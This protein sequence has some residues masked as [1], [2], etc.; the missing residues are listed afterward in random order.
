MRLYKSP[1]PPPELAAEHRESQSKMLYMVVERHWRV[2]AIGQNAK[3]I[4]LSGTHSIW[5]SS[6][7]E[8][9]LL[10]TD[11]LCTACRVL[12]RR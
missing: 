6:L 12:T 2:C 5:F 9:A 8:C 3:S 10:I 11:L 7:A 1:P 4:K